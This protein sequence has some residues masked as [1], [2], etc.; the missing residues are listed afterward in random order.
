MKISQVCKVFNLGLNSTRNAFKISVLTVMPTEN[1]TF[2]PKFEFL[3]LK[4]KI[5]IR[6]IT[7]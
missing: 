2:G 6:K 4:H 5:E 7:T 1:R 3:K